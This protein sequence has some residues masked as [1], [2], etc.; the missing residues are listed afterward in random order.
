[1]QLL[2]P[3]TAVTLGMLALNAHAAG[4]SPWRRACREIRR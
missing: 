2:V 1:M 3:L 4:R